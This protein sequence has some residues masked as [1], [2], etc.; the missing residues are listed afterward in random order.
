MET[1]GREGIERQ[2]VMKKNK[3]K[4]YILKK[5]C[6]HWCSLSRVHCKLKL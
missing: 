3:I 2:M 5:I 4:S 1:G 6:H